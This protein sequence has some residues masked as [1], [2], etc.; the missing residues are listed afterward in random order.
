MVSE[1]EFVGD[2][3][4]RHRFREILGV[5]G[6][7]YRTAGLGGRQNERVKK[8]H[9]RPKSN[10]GCRACNPSID[11]DDFEAGEKLLYLRPRM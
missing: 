6:D 3:D 10:I 7:E 2:S 9:P 4:A 1:L 11:L 8:L 5:S